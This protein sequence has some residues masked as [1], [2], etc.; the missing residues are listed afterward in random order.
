MKKD[1]FHRFFN[2]DYRSFTKTLNIPADAIREAK[3]NTDNTVYI[4]RVSDNHVVLTQDGSE[5]NL[6]GKINGWKTPSGT[7]QYRIGAQTLFNAETDSVMIVPDNY[8]KS[9]DIIGVTFVE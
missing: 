5:G 3:F 4:K 7:K 9:I 1:A 2:E 6:I 8:F